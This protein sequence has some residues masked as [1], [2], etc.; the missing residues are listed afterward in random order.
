MNHSDIE[1]NKI[2][3]ILSDDTDHQ[4]ST[5]ERTT[6]TNN[7]IILDTNVDT[8][9]Q[10]TDP[11]FSDLV[12]QVEKLPLLFSTAVILKSYNRVFSQCRSWQYWHLCTT[13]NGNKLETVE[14]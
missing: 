10:D 12:I 8:H 11:S 3:D 5:Y 4:P 9:Q 6:V 2:A 14:S 1:K 13:S 7:D